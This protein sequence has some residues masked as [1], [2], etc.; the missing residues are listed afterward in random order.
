MSVR[1]TIIGIGNP[2]VDELARVEEAIVARAGGE[3]GG[4]ELVDGDLLLELA[5]MIPSPLERSPGGSAGN[6][7]SALARLGA[8]AAMVGKLGRDEAGGYYRDAL[9]AAGGDTGRFLYSDRIP[10]GRC[11]CLVTPDS[12]RTMRTHLGAAMTLTPDEIVPGLF[13]GATHVH[14]EGY[15]LFNPD[16]IR[17]V[18]ETAAD[19]RRTVSLDLASFEVVRSAHAELPDLLAR[20]VDL[21]FANEEEAQAYCGSDDPAAGLDS[22]A[23]VCRIAAVKLGGAGALIREH[24]KTIRAPAERAARVIDTTG[25]GDFWAAGFLHGWTQGADGETC[26]RFGARLGA[27]VVQHIGAR[28]PD[29]AWAAAREW[30]NAALERAPTGTR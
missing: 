6:T 3:K 17:A 2:I 27:Q 30:M 16:L 26:G 7:V 19:G 14:V 15:L 18:L 9:R 10:T 23:D 25:A 11:L 4:M 1:P 29:A 22:L 20:Y 21:V 5:A 8:A 24:G 28:L 13:D 12:E